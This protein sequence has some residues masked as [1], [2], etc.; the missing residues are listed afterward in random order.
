MTRSINVFM[1]VPTIYA[2]LIDD[3][4]TRFN[5]SSLTKQVRDYVK[6][7]CQ[8]K[9]RFGLLYVQSDAL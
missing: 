2:K 1:A 4:E 6:A 3:F 8:N 5:S 7:T 9:I